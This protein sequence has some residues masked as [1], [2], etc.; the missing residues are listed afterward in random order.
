MIRLAPVVAALSTCFVAGCCCPATTP[1]AS[2]SA[3]RAR[4]LIEEA[5]A[6][7]PYLP[8]ATEEESRARLASMDEYPRVP[9]LIR[10]A[11]VL[12]KTVDADMAAWKALRAETTLDRRLLNEV[13][14]VVS[15]ANECGH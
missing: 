14:W 7:E 3:A 1:P 5:K 10:I 8:M 2:G 13:F 15:S 4:R 12:P 6:R 11:S 9:N